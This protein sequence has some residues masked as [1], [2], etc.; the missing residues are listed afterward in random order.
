MA[1]ERCTPRTTEALVPRSRL[2]RAVSAAPLAPVGSPHAEA[3]GVQLQRDAL[4]STFVKI[5]KV[6]AY[7]HWRRR[8]AWFTPAAEM[9]EHSP[10]VAF[11]CWLV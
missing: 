1:K 3:A 7:Y 6:R 4:F 10:R 11:E 2:T 8:L 9:I 5:E